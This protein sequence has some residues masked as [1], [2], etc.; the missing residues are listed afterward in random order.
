MSHT[1]F[2]SDDTQ[3][4]MLIEEE[5]DC[6]KNITDG[7]DRVS[8]LEEVAPADGYFV[9]GSCAEIVQHKHILLETGRLLQVGALVYRHEGDEIQF[10]LITSRGTGRWIIPKGWPMPGCTLAAAASRE[11]YEEAGI[12]G[13]IE[14]KVC[15]SY[16]YEKGD[17]ARGENNRCHDNN[18]SKI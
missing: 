5:A 14:A 3:K 15:G 18:L 4:K 7:Y 8:F 2:K 6:S 17:L 13:A 11:A 9:G 10:L 16:D 12:C 1:L